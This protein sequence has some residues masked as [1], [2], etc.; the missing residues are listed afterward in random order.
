M[1]ARVLITGAGMATPVGLSALETFASVRSGVTR[2]DEQAVLDRSLEPVYMGFV[3]GDALPSAAEKLSGEARVT[4]RELRML[5]LC[6]LAIEDLLTACE[7]LPPDRIPLLLALPEP[8]GPLPVEPEQFLRRLEMQTGRAFVKQGTACFRAGRAAGIEALAEGWRRLSEGE[9]AVVLVAAVDSYC[10]LRRIAA[11]DLQRRLKSESNRDGFTPGEGACFLLL[12]TDELASRSSCAPQAEILGVA[13]GLE[14]GHLGSDKP[15]T[16]DGLASTLQALFAL[17]AAQGVR[18]AQVY[19]TMNGEHHWA[20]EWGVAY[21]RNAES[22]EPGF[23]MHHTAE[24]HGDAGAASGLIGCGLV[25][26]GCRLGLDEGPAL[27]Y[28]SSDHGHRS[29]ALLRSF[30]STR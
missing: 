13:T 9:S 10:D 19:S 21:L 6:A 7:E 17:P 14:T 20:K 24:F 15:C 29:A 25:A 8:D 5:G 22:M 27:V 1:S 12:M 11:L 2:V 3:P 23:T 18:A 26:M 4:S 30:R 16:G 28:A